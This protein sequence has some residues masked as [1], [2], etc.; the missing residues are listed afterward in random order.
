MDKCNLLLFQIVSWFTN[1]FRFSYNLVTVVTETFR[2]K[3]LLKGQVIGI[4]KQRAQGPFGT[5]FSTN[6]FGWVPTKISMDLSGY[7]NIRIFAGCILL[8]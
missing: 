2:S 5:Q 7:S 6:S 8:R 1:D 4:L 3:C